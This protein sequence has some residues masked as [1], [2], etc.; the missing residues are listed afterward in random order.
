MSHHLDSPLARQ[1]PRLDITDVY[2][3]QGVTGTVFVI[4]VNPLSGVNGFH[5]EG[6]YEF[7]VDTNSDAVEDLTFRV[8]FGA[9]ASDERQALELRRL[10]GAT[11]RD[12]RAEGIVLAG[13]HT[14]EEIRGERGIRIWAGSAADPFYIE[15]NV[16]GAVKKA[17]AE[18]TSV[19]LNQWDSRKAAS[20]FA[21]TNVNAIVLE[22]PDAV[23]DVA[24]IG[25]WGVTALPTDAGE[26]RQ[27]NRCAQP[28]INTIFNPDDSERANQYNATQ[29]S[30]DRQLYGPLVRDL[31]AR[32]V[33]TMGTASDPK[34]YGRQVSDAIFPDLLRYEIGTPANF[35]FVRRNGRSL[36]D[37]TPEVMF[38]LVLNK[39]VPLGLDSRSATGTLRSEFPYLAPPVVAE[40][41][42]P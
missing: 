31:V 36:T 1:D 10:D 25:F 11:A 15:G 37:C 30:E 13:G 3:F 14:E 28:L 2:L 19:D 32:I 41:S 4:N 5:P 34:D 22:V 9:R 23:F 21:G 40:A 7:K 27:I 6:L 8:T 33:A 42:Q 18:G 38:G 20:I 16:I 12:R 26:W 29:P 35:G 17:V 24:T 39:A